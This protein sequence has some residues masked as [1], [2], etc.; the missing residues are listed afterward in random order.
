MERARQS[1]ILKTGWALGM[2]L[3]P[4]EDWCATPRT[5]RLR[6]AIRP[7]RRRGRDEVELSTLMERDVIRAA[8]ERHRGNVTRAAGA[9]QA[10]DPAEVRAHA[11][12]HARNT[13]SAAREV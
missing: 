3:G 6:L 12:R 8:P 11:I 10:N 7:V 2:S 4:G 1:G 5:E 9:W 13:E